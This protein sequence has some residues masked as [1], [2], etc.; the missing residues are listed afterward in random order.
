[1]TAGVASGAALGLGLALL[2]VSMRPAR[3]SLASALDRLEGRAAPLGPIGLGTGWPALRRVVAQRVV[4]AAEGAGLPLWR[5][6]PELA[7]AGMTPADLVGDALVGVVGGAAVPWIAQAVLVSGGAGAPPAVIGL[8]SVVLALAG[9]VLP[10][11]VLRRRA[12]ARRAHV[13]HVLGAFCDLV[14]LAL[15]G[16]AGVEG[17][18]EA[19]EV[20]GRDWAIGAISRAV[21]EARLSGQPPWEGLAELGAAWGVAELAELGA[22]LA[23]AGTEGARVRATLRAKA[24][25]LRRHELEAAESEAN[26]VTERMF[27]PGTLLLAG[28]LVFLG[29]PAMA[30][31]FH[32]L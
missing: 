29:Y 1:M 18:L 16:G 4:L 32:L 21:A 7:A 31:I 6:A 5:L 20:A 17:A 25:S 23:L 22:N 14:A 26:S 10:L 19:P 24:A 2:A 11:A 9:L 30:R 27:L 12:A 3:P 28:F 13:R 15:A 8:I